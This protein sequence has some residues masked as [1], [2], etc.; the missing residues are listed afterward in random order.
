MIKWVYVAALLIG[1]LSLDHLFL[2]NLPFGLGL[3]SGL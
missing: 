3:H 1:A 2:Q